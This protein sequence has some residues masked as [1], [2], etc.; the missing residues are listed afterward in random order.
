MGSG[1]LLPPPGSPDDLDCLDQDSNGHCISWISHFAWVKG[2]GTRV[3]LIND[4]RG[5]LPGNQYAS[6]DGSYLLLTEVSSTEVSLIAKNGTTARFTTNSG[7][8]TGETLTDTNG[9]TV[10]CTASNGVLTGC[11]DTM[12]RQVGF[13]LDPASNAPVTMS[14][15]DSSGTTRIVNFH[16][17]TFT[18]SY[19][20]GSPASGGPCG[21]SRPSPSNHALLTSVTLANGLSYNFEYLTNPDGSTTGEVTKITLPTG[22]YI[23]Y[24]YGGG[25]V[26]ATACTTELTGQDRMVTHRFISPDGTSVAEQ[27]W[28]YS[29]TTTTNVAAD[30]VTQT[31]T[32][33]DPQGSSQVYTRDT[34]SPLPVQID[35]KDAAGAVI[36]STVNTIEEGGADPYVY[37]PAGGLP[38]SLNNARYKDATTVLTDA[39]QK[40]QSTYTYD[41]FNNVAEKDETDW[42][43]GAPGAVLRK[44]TY[45]YLADSTPAYAADSVHILD[46][47]TSSKTCDAGSTFCA[48]TNITYDSTPLTATTNVVQHDYTSFSNANALRGNPSVISRVVGNTSLSTTNTYNDVGNLIKT[49]GSDG[50]RHVL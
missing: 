27:N 26:G 46:R 6:Y 29:L 20:L 24:V 4:P 32:V 9:N 49:G 14:Y 36:K 21:I 30:T 33:T 34:R 40:A 19:P 43:T 22:G 31:M 37:S 16:Y 15:L 1:R 18:V 35:Y 23:R 42:G 41:S 2:D 48:Q 12:G 3:D 8:V 13:T 25:A 11:T 39:N 28:S 47:V 5:S 7:N 17:S 45:T 50:K 38:P 44:M 10:A